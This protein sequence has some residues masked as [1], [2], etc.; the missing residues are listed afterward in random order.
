MP[1]DGDA[2]WQIEIGAVD[3]SAQ[4]FAAV[5]RRMRESSRQAMAL[6]QQTSL[7]N[8]VA[9]AAMTRLS[10]ALAPLAAGFTAAAVA[11]R[12]WEAGMKAANM[13]EQAEQI[14]LTTDQLQAYRLA[15]AQAGIEAEQMDGAMMRLARAMG[16][17]N[18]G[19][20]EAIARFEKLGVKILDSGG[21]LRKAADVMPELARGLLQIGSETERAALMQELFG[22]SGARLVTVLGQIAQ[23][24]DAVV[25]SA[26]AQKAVIGEEVIKAWDELDDQMKVA[27]QRM[28]TFLATVGKPIAVG[29][30]QAINFEIDKITLGLRLAQ[31]GFDWL[32]SKA[33][34]SAGGLD[35]QIEGM[36]ADIVA[37]M[38]RGHAVDDPVVQDIIK[39]RD[40]LTAQLNAMPP[41]MPEITVTA[42]Q[43]GASNPLSNG[44]KKAGEK[45]AA[46]ALRESQ[47]QMDEL[48]ALIEKQRQAADAIEDRFGTGAETLARKTQELADIQHLLAPETAQRAMQD[49]TDKAD[50]QARAMTGA[51]GG[52]DG[53]MAGIEQGIADMARVNT[54]FETG[55]QMVDLMSDAITDLAMGAEVDFGKILKSF[56]NMMIQ[57]EIKAAASSLWGAI[58]GGGGIGGFIGGLFG[59]GGGVTASGGGFDIGAASGL[60]GGWMPGF[61]D[62]GRPPLGRPSVVG[63][64]GPELFVPDSAGTIFNREQLGGMGGETTIVVQQTVHVGEYVTSTQYMS[65]LRE[66]KKA[67]EEGAK[68]SIISMRK[69]GGLTDV[70]N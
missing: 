37:F 17:A 69:R 45:S 3:R 62:G 1:F 16:S 68:A 13:G 5:D 7:A 23:G 42:P 35:K 44:A 65:G 40:A 4:A 21:N 38:G 25:A 29:A 24:N 10:A 9:T 55:K 36:N 2:R 32:T 19:S 46:D 27:A 64:R 66:V 47:R 20:D 18:D 67:A 57:M 28:D 39:R 63:E 50:D 31:K 12:I 56:L 60:A 26:K 58:G 43:G 70:F 14:G 34:N 8:N 15:A 48:V 11:S 61:A 30:L 54:E 41:T 52:F 59:G 6:G 53:F 51:A 49:L 33:A 22:R